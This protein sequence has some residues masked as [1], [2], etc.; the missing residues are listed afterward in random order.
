VHFARAGLATATATETTGSFAGGTA[1]RA[2]ARGVRESLFCVELLF[3]GGKGE[4]AAAFAA[5]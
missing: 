5:R 4:V 1:L 3:T 2:T